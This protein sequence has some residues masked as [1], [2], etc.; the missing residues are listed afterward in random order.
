MT[1]KIIFA[2]LALL[3]LSACNDTNTSNQSSALDDS[4]WTDDQKKVM[5]D[6][7]LGVVVPYIDIGEAHVEYDH[8]QDMVAIMG[9]NIVTQDDLKAYEQKCIAL[10][11]YDAKGSSQVSSPY[12]YNFKK[13]KSLNPI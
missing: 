4:G 11:W 3:T 10:G 5:T 7:L 1:K 12:E 2:L 13:N 6:N 8:D 9:S